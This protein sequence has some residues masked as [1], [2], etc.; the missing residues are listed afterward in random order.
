MRF[1]IFVF[2]L[3]TF[4]SSSL[5]AKIKFATTGHPVYAI[6]KEIV[7]ESADM[8]RLLPPGASPHVYEPKPNDAKEASY[9]AIL[10][11]VSDNLDGWTNK[12]K[13]KQKIALLDLVEN[14]NLRYF[15]K[16][17]GSNAGID[18]HFWTD[19]LVVKQ[20]APKLAEIIIQKDPANKKA[21]QDNLAKFIS[22]LDKLNSEIAQIVA[23]I[24]GK[25]VFLHHPSFIYFCY[26]YG[27]N[28]AGAIEEY[29]GKEPTPKTIAMLA[30]KVKASGAKSVFNEPQLSIKSI[31]AIAK[32]SGAKVELLDPNGGENGR[33]TYFELMRFN[34]FQLVNSLK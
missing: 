23:P 25:D 4:Y 28:Y 29:P 19:P 18:P 12:L 1:Y 2:A 30:K 17:D 5:N 22:N 20:I 31:N 21:Y 15:I 27:L 13:A 32:A 7:G 11:Y 10:F 8:I 24:K 26:R 34:A 14:N 33:F 9:S 3:I 16:M 6:V